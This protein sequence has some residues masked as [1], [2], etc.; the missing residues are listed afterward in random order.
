M[1]EYD[2]WNHP[3]EP[4]DGELEELVAEIGQELTLTLLR[5]CWN[6]HK[7]QW[8]GLEDQNA[9]SYGPE[10]TRVICWE[11]FPEE[12]RWGHTAQV[13]LTYNYG[14]P[15]ETTSLASYGVNPSTGDISL[16]AD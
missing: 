3:T 11:K 4:I 6:E 1:R 5:E 7:E 8:S 14:A 16:Y 10:Q 2:L 15:S 13:L 12:N 9:G